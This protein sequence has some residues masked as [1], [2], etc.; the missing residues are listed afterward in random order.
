MK[1][2]VVITVLIAAMTAALAAGC[3]GK[4]EEASKDGKVHIQF[5]HMQVEQERQDAVQALIDD[6]E[7]ENP[8]IE[9]E[10]IPVNEDDYDSKITAQ[11]GSGELADV[12]EY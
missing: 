9:V 6:F 10:A 7:K 2:K 1:R 11:G 3:G 8:D 5:M 12:V 4:K